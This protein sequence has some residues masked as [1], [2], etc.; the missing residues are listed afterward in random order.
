VNA[1]EPVGVGLPG[2]SRNEV[3]Q[4]GTNGAVRVAAVVR[5]PGDHTGSGRAGVAQT[6]SVVDAERVHP[7]SP[8]TP[9]AH[10]NDAAARPAGD[11]LPG[12]HAQNQAARV[13]VT[14]VTWM[15]STP[16]SASAHMHQR[17][18]KQD[19]ELA[20]GSL[21]NLDAWSLTNS[22]K[23]LTSFRRTEYGQCRGGTRSCFCQAP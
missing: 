12:F 15:P 13:A 23:A 17:P 6:C 20:S 2:M 8:T 9:M 11:F 18:L 22:K 16:S 21:L 7:S 14:E 5:D 3:Q 1:F 10:G 19:T 4:P